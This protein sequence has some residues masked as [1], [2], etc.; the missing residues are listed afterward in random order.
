MQTLG[1]FDAYPAKA[2]VFVGIAFDG[3]LERVNFN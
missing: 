3:I 1:E 2:I